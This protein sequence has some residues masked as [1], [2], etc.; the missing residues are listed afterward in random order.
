MNDKVAIV[1]AGPGL[2]S[3][4]NILLSERI[5][6]VVVGEELKKMRDIP[7]QFV[8]IPLPPPPIVKKHSS[9]EKEQWKHRAR[10]HR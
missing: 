8:D 10:K 9:N 2:V 5:E 4:C 7:I 3:L 6:V 1:G